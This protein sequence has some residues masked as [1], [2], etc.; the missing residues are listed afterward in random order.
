ML[1]HYFR[2]RTMMKSINRVAVLIALSGSVAMA[3]LTRAA[4][5]INPAVAS[6]QPIGERDKIEFQQKN[7]SAQ[8]Q[9]LEERMYRLAELIRESEPSDSARLLMG[10]Q[11]AREELITEQMKGIV[12]LIGEKDLNKASDEQ[13]QVLIKL[14]ELKRLLA[15]GDLDLQL[16]LER[17]KKL[18]AALEKL[19]NA[20]KEENRQ[21]G[22]S[23]KLA[24]EQSKNPKLEPKPFNQLK[25]DQEGNRKS[26]DAVKD[27]VKTLGE[28]PA[29]SAETLNSASSTMS[30]AEASFTSQNAS[31]ATGQQAQALDALKKARQQLEAERQKMLAEIERQV[32]KQVIENLTRMLETQT[33]VRE[34]TEALSPRLTS[35]RQAELRI[36]QLGGT[37]QKIADL[38]EATVTLVEE[39]AFSIALPPALKSIQRRV[40]YVAVDL[41][42][43]HGGETVITPEKEIERDLKDLIDTFKELPSNPKQTS[44]C[45]G[46]KGN[47]NKLLAELKVLRML[48]AR[49]NED[50]LDIDGRRARAMAE[51]DDEIRKS[52]GSTA[53]HQADVRDATEKIHK[54]TCPDCLSD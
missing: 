54:A 13:K 24:G 26:T 31:Q 15:T 52:L 10:V 5:P 23:K 33:A 4:A 6:T 7:A 16:Q 53:R 28:G 43:G 36:K 39:T 45:K 51:A 42:A 48:Q 3:P 49:V 22:E 41:R 50:T 40:T 27:I 30:N 2:G 46:C 25:T 14:D 35:E 21:V 1:A 32:K 8:F 17:L 38:A 47:K 19:D 44:Q 18:N 12:G 9:E 34:A 37:E 20:I 29:K 11:R